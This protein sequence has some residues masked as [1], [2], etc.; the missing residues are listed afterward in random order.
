MG[1][2]DVGWERAL[3]RITSYLVGEA[4]FCHVRIVDGELNSATYSRP[5]KEINDGHHYT[6]ELAVS[7]DRVLR[8]ILTFTPSVPLIVG[9][10]VYPNGKHRDYL[11]GLGF[12]FDDPTTTNYAPDGWVPCQVMVEGATTLRSLPLVA[13][14]MH[15]GSDGR[16]FLVGNK[17][18]RGACGS[19]MIEVS[20]LDSINDTS[21]VVATICDPSKIR[22]GCVVCYCA[23]M[24]AKPM[25][26]ECFKRRPDLTHLDAG[27]LFDR[28]YGI[29]NRTWHHDKGSIRQKN[30]DKFYIP[31]I[32][33][34]G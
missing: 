1:P 29:Q 12:K 7:L 4:P 24:A 18:I 33:A 6:K 25:L 10:T 20:Q 11:I 32:R 16:L 17:R 31:L 2:E 3:D 26:W 14:L 15:L 34:F 8:E 19:Q 27:H 13:K 9:G 23:G 21:R 5:E 30:Y 22:S 28:A